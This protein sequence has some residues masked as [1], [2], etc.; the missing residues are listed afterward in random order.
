MEADIIL[1]GGKL[2][3]TWAG[4]GTKRRAVMQRNAPT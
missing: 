4:L 3:A 2:A 1:W